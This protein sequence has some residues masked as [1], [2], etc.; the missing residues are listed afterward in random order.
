[1]ILFSTERYF[2]LTRELGFCESDY[3]NALAKD[4]VCRVFIT[5][6]GA[7]EGLKANMHKLQTLQSF[8]SI[9]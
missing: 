8:H 5:Q 3:S 2:S 7:Q 4:L 1:M 9:L 6:T